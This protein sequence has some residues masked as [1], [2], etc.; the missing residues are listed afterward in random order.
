MRRGTRRGRGS[1]AQV[2]EDLDDHRRIF[3][4][5]PEPDEGAAM[6]FKAPPQFG[7]RL[8]S[9]S[10]TRFSSRAQLMRAGAP[11]ALASSL[12]VS[13]ARSAGAGTILLRNFALAP[14]RDFLSFRR[15]GR[16][17]HHL[18]CWTHSG[19]I[20]RATRRAAGHWSSWAIKHVLNKPL[21]LQ[22]L[23]LVKN[24]RSLRVCM[25]CN[26]ISD[27]QIATYDFRKFPLF[28]LGAKY[29]MVASP[30]SG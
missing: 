18:A 19:H 30:S 28:P 4:A 29:F 22:N 23:I 6:I 17:L 3:D 1:V 7:Q 27:I 14:A 15:L 10:K 21:N 11:C 20:F 9:I 25:G 8:M 2:A 26:G 5:C 13:V 16:I 12:E 24:I